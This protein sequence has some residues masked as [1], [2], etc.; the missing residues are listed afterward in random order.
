MR[1][2][3][4]GYTE[5]GNLTV[6]EKSVEHY[7]VNAV[8]MRAGHGVIQYG[9]IYPEH[10]VPG[11]EEPAGVAISRGVGFALRLRRVIHKGVPK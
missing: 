3:V 7:D 5:Y 2:A 10:G 11:T 9:V 8:L 6:H 4:Y 1:Y